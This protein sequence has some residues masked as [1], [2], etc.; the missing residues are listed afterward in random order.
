MATSISSSWHRE[1]LM[2]SDKKAKWIYWATT[3]PF[4]A[5]M[6]SAGLTYL[7]GASFNVEGITHLG[8]PVY[9]PRILGPAK[10]LG[11]V[12]I[13][14]GRSRALKEWAYA[15]YTFNLVGA[16]ASHALYGDPFVKVMVP[17]IILAFVLVS[18]R[19][20]KTGRT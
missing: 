11:G 16:S 7:A 15:G 12:A 20:W 1:W 9:L 19:Q 17:I 6:M 3:I 5:T 18:Y 13:L 14:Q 10:L 8:Y 4:V 2:R